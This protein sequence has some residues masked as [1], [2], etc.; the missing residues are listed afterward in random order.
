[1]TIAPRS[2]A[3]VFFGATGDLASKMIFPALQ[4][5][6]RHGTLE[7]PIIGVA[8]SGMTLGD[9]QKRARA[10]LVEH[11]GGVDEAAFAKLVRLLRYVDGDYQ[12]PKTFETLKSLLA[13][14]KRPLHYLAIPPSLFPDVIGQLGRS[15]CAVGARVVVEKPFGHDLASAQKLHTTIRKV[16]SESDI[17]RIDHYLGKEAVQDLVVFRFANQFFEPT[18]NREH[19]R[20]VQ[21]TMAEQFGI[22]GRGAFYDANGAIRDVVQNHLMQVIGLLAMERPSS[23]GTESIGDSVANLFRQIKPLGAEQVVRGQFAGYRAE[24]G[25]KP[26]SNVE[27][28]AALRLD[29]DSSRWAGVPFFI[30]TGK[31]LPISVTEVVAA[32]RRTSTRAFSSSDRNR[33]RFRL[34]PDLRITL[35]AQLK[36]PGEALIG[37]SR[38]LALVKKPVSDGMTA[39]ERLLGDA[40]AG[41][42][43]LFARQDSVEASW[44]VVDGA[45]K[46][47]SP[48]HVYQRGSWG[49]GI[50]DR[51]TGHFGG[52][53]DISAE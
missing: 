11:G 37:E 44:A 24:P 25:V 47:A 41:D 1:M 34:S 53:A 7:V 20:S 30:R 40:M 48:V 51:L 33:W 36:Q 52:W 23:T 21:I 46:D 6:L 9:L 32:F 43:T 39:Y 4:S 45:L 26:D 12:D 35:N 28:Y 27:T 19:V 14:S 8:K 18:W 49:P 3:F 5:M 2:D 22:H 10:S 38:Q 13:N 17:F 16:F 31:C 15:G 29:I 50:A 42:K